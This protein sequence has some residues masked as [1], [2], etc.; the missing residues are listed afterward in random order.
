MDT[1]PEIGE[2]IVN[3]NVPI[4]N[5]SDLSDEDYDSDLKR[6]IDDLD[7]EDMITDIIVEIQKYTDKHCLSIFNYNLN[8]LVRWKW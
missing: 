4:D 1:E 6:Q 3:I 7:R 8:D 5:E 2:V